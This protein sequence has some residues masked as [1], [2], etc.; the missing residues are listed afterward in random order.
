MLVKSWDV[1]SLYIPVALNCC[2][3]PSA[4]DVAPELRR[5]IARS[6]DWTANLN[7]CSPG[8]GKRE[9]ARQQRGASVWGLPLQRRV[10]LVF[11]FGKNRY[12]SENDLKE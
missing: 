11:T 1:P 5:R 3:T 4:T 6:W 8:A 2:W 9:E 12:D 7:C 10:K